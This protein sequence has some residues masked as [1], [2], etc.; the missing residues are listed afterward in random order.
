MK[1][2]LVSA[3]IVG[4]LAGVVTAEEITSNGLGGGRWSE[5]DTWR[6]GKA[7]GPEDVAVIAARDAVLFDRDDAEAVTCKQLVLDPGSNFAF[8]NGLGKRTL[9]V[10]GPIEIY[11]SLKLHAPGITDSLAIRLDSEVY[12][13][14]VIT[15]ARG[16]SL[17]VLGKANLPG[18]KK[19]VSITVSAPPVAK[20]EAA[21]ELNAGEGTTIDLQNAFIENLAITA[22]MIDNTG[23]KPGERCNFVGNRFAKQ[24]RLT[25]SQCDTAAVVR[26]VF[27]TSREGITRPH[28][29]A[30]SSSPLADIRANTLTGRYAIGIGI[31]SSESLL[32]GN[33][34]DGSVQGIVWHTGP[35]MM[36]QNSVKNCATGVS[37][38][39]VSGNVEETTI[40]SC[41]MPLTTGSSKVQLSNLTITD[42]KGEVWVESTGSSVSFLNTNVRPERFKAIRGEDLP[43]S[44]EPEDPAALAYEYLVAGLAGTVPPGADVEVRTANPA[45]PPKPGAADM[46]VRNSP[47]TVRGNK[48]TPLP[49]SLTPLIVRSWTIDAAGKVLSP[50]AYILT[51]RAP[52]VGAD[53]V[54]K[55]L[56]TIPLTPDEKWFR[57][58]PNDLLP[59]VEIT[60]P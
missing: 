51:V 12:A 47:A 35:A 7:P 49:A 58:K 27:E 11:G 23:A 13:E 19:N 5:P 39:T 4:S 41:E 28:G 44:L 31:N 30:V 8:Q 21:G 48:L 10:K 6:G 42:V 50:P 15:V 38:R 53:G 22:Q 34:V 57:A 18:G 20:V 3:V 46:N 16:G 54:P 36:K 40:E 45:T 60:L 32:T 37:L 52:A 26:N 1:N 59:T 25:V 33:T 24:A 55:P 29:L 17:L 14:R 2:W 43:R 56:K 9:T